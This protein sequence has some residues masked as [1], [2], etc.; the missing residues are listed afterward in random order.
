MIPSILVNF[1]IVKNIYLDNAATTPMLP[2]VIE[3]V[4]SA[5]ST[6]YGNPSST[7]QIGRKAKA[8]VE[9]AR[10]NIAK[11]FNANSSEIYFTAGATEAD[12]LILKNAVV[13]LKVETII[14]S[15]IEHHAILHTIENLENCATCS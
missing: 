15:K 5:M 10:K 1:A 14:L 7:H 11:Q 4:T 8:M 6:I 13:N 2:E 3:T 9:T 12:N